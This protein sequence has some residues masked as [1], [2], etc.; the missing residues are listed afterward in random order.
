MSLSLMK[1]YLKEKKGS[2]K[3]KQSREMVFL[4][5]TPQ[6]PLLLIMYW[7]CHFLGPITTSTL[8]Q[9]AKQMKAEVL[10]QAQKSTNVLSRHVGKK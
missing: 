2:K 3:E 6:L 8:D 7:S 1:C 4:K 5:T 10:Q 9:L